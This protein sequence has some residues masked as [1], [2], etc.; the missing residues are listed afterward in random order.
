MSKH[1]K[2]SERD[3]R[4][5]SVTWD[6]SRHKSISTVRVEVPYLSKE[7]SHAAEWDAS[8]S[9]KSDN[10]HACAVALSRRNVL[11]S[12]DLPVVLPMASRTFPQ[13]VQSD[14]DERL[15]ATLPHDYY[16]LI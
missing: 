1:N 5:Y 9:R 11:V 8:S 4:K 13:S 16:G 6:A 3:R 10:I 12:A 7:M 2:E 14:V 15:T